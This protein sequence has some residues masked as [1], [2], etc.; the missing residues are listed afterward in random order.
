[1]NG[2]LHYFLSVLNP[3]TNLGFSRAVIELMS[4]ELPSWWL[5]FRSYIRRLDASFHCLLARLPR[6]PGLDTPAAAGAPGAKTA[7]GF[8]GDRR[9]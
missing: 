5:V 1:M 7:F 2:F 3:M 4:S 8:G 6:E 9:A